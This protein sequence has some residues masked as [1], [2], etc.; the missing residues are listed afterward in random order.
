MAAP[1]GV[2]SPGEA[3]AEEPGILDKLVA[4]IINGTVQIP[5]HVIDAAAS[6][7][8]PGLRREDYTD[9][10]PP[11]GGAP[12]GLSPQG[13]QPGDEMRAASTDAAAGLAGVGTSFA[14]PGAAGIFGGRLAATADKA[15][16]ARAEEMA[17][18]GADRQAIWDKTG[19][20]KGSDD[21]WRFEIPDYRSQMRQDWHDNGLPNGEMGS[22]ASQLWH[23]PL[24]EAYPD[25]RRI[26]GMTEKSAGESG[27][28]SPAFGGNSKIVGRDEVINI[29]APNAPAARS[30]ALH[31]MQHAIQEREGF[32][33][34]GSPSMFSQSDDAKLARE[35]LSYRQEIAGLD[36]K[37]TPKQKDDIIRKRYEDMGAPDWLPSQAARDVA[38]DVHGNPAG[39][40]RRVM[41]LYGTDKTIGGFTPRQLYRELPG[42][43]EARNVQSRRDMTPAE[44]R[45]RPPWQTADIDARPVMN[46]I[47]GGGRVGALESR[48]AR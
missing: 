17:A 15:A 12:F 11:Q 47:F 25:L 24:Y 40:L 20:F 31:E 35:A 9:I 44:L 2:L 30:V 41:E 22:I 29:Q 13:W 43:I 26:T 23:K 21:K 1:F 48:G 14:V 46:E 3:G 10:P 36:P 28:Y 8:P 27:S 39:T 4:G 18:G 37:L 16:L 42:E 5:K 6:S 45:A 32:A 38:H 7:A 34:G 19:W 33:Q